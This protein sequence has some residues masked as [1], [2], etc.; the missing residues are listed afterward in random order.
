MGNYMGWV[1]KEFPG[2]GRSEA[3]L[4]QVDLTSGTVSCWQPQGGSGAREA[5]SGDGLAWLSSVKVV[6]GAQSI[7]R[8]RCHSFGVYV[9]VYLCVCAMPHIHVAG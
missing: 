3:V 6:K 4:W 7:Q 1:G 8:G 5:L 2:G 9:R